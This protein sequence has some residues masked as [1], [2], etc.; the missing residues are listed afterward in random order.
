MANLKSGNPIPSFG[1]TLKNPQGGKATPGKNGKVSGG[2]AKNYAPRFNKT[3]T[4]GM[5]KAGGNG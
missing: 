1:K 5:G 4:K 3:P 2:G